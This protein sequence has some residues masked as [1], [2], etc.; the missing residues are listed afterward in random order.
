M[1]GR[2]KTRTKT[3]RFD[4]GV[5]DRLERAANRANMSENEF[6]SVLLEDRLLIDP[7]VPAF[8][9]MWLS[10]DAVQ[11]FMVAANVDVLE[12]ASSEMAQ[13]N[14][15]LIFKLYETNQ[16][17]LDF[18]KFVTDVLGKYCHWFYVEGDDNPH[19]ITLRH[20]YGLKWSKYV[21]AYI[22]SAYGTTSKGTI[23][24]EITDQL[25]RIETPH[26]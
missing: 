13:R 12:V 7:L 16:I 25:I 19:W 4:V 11:S 5:V 17:P 20:A 10:S 15:P 8:H 24:V 26:S 22:L 1:Q 3:F 6:V 23:E 14:F 18:R 2:K 9:G 21:R